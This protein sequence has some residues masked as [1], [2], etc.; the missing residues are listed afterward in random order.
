MYNEFTEP[1]KSAVISP[2]LDGGIP[3]KQKKF[4]AAGVEKNIP[5]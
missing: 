1:N 3:G 5:L 2:A 4:E